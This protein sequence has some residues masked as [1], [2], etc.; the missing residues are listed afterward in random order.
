MIP[1]PPVREDGVCAL[2]GCTKPR[3]VAVLTGKKLAELRRYAGHQIEA[4]PFCSSRCARKWHG[5]ALDREEDEELVDR[6]SA[7]GRRARANLA[8]KVAA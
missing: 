7:A 2:P 8:R 4:D 3:P 1:D 6:R 5:C